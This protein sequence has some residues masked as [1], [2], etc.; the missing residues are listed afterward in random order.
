MSPR[1]A[2][3]CSI[4]FRQSAR[5]LHYRLPRRRTPTVRLQV[6][7]MVVVGAPLLVIGLTL[8][9]IGAGQVPFLLG[10]LLTA[11]GLPILAWAVASY[12]CHS[13]VELSRDRLILTE[14]FGPFPLRRMR[15]IDHLRRLT[16]YRV[17]K[18]EWSKPPHNGVLEVVCEG[19]QSLWFAIGYPCD[20][21]SGLAAELAERY[22]LPGPDEPRDLPAG[23]KIEPLFMS[24]V[25]D[26]DTFDR[27]DRPAGSKIVVEQA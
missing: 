3:S 4:T 11:V 2:L 16:P 18:G 17:Q 22:A 26:E 21:L 27:P 7:L 6:F 9:C 13:A 19:S 8:I 14:W 1:A 24:R 5:G 15:P 23:V 12:A 20:L 25:R 10:V